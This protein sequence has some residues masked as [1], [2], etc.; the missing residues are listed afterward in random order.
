MA[1]LERN[2]VR[3][4]DQRQFV[5]DF[6][7]DPARGATVIVNL[8]DGV[9]ERAIPRFPRGLLCKAEGLRLSAERRGRTGQARELV[10]VLGEITRNEGLAQ[11]VTRVSITQERGSEIIVEPAVNLPKRLERRHA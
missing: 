7:A 3:R 1:D 11:L 5:A 2:E 6:N 8:Q 9:T 4:L 10:V